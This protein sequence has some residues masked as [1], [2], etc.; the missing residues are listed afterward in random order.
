[1]RL[2]IPKGENA[3]KEPTSFPVPMANHVFFTDIQFVIVG[4]PI[5]NILG[6]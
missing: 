6:S 2:K 5:V 3:P 1:M 4:R